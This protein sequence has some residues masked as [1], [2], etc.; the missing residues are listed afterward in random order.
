MLSRRLFSVG[1]IVLAAFPSLRLHVEDV[2]TPKSPAEAFRILYR[3]L[4]APNKS[5]QISA[6]K[7]FQ[8]LIR[9]AGFDYLGNNVA[10]VTADRNRYVF[11]FKDKI[12]DQFI[13][14]NDWGKTKIYT[15]LDEAVKGIYG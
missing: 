6:T 5:E 2:D 1:G 4:T 8:E 14:N 9:L 15:S 12:V 13:E 7:N 10:L 11:L 3:I